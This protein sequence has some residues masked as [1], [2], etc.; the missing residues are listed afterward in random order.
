MKI[1]L[2]EDIQ[3]NQELVRLRMGQRQ[4]NIVV[5]ENG[6]E[7]L[8]WLAQEPFD[9]ILMDAHMPIMNGFDAIREIRTKERTTG[10]HIPIIMLTASVLESD[11][12]LCF[13]AGAD[14]FVAKPID[15]D[16]LYAKIGRHFPSF[17][18]TPVPPSEPPPSDFLEGVALDLIDLDAGLRLWKSPVVYRKALLKL[19]QQYA[20]AHD[21]VVDLLSNGQAQGARQL[22]HTLKG[23]T[24][25]LAIRELPAIS[26]QI[27]SLIKSDEPVPGE[28][29]ER[30]ASTLERLLADL[31][32]IEQAGS[33]SSSATGAG[34]RAPLDV[35][36]VVGLLDTLIEALDL[37]ELADEAIAGLREA[38]DADTFESLEEL[39]DSFELEEASNHAKRLR[40]T[41]SGNTGTHD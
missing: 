39:I 27:E 37:S 8:D 19:G 6:Q 28:A 35:A 25:N 36:H 4:H 1:L 26:N 12:A 22:L 24:A 20:D 31:A 33:D 9:L 17:T 30:L 23:V 10:G 18:H 32:R 15:F 3:L 11:Q 16:D 38:L 5:A 7:A 34:V 2:V 14:D 21:R 40:A 29:L 13:D 41:L